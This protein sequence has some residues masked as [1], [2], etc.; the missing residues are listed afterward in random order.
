MR[1]N[2]LKPDP[3]YQEKAKDRELINFC[4]NSAR[5][6]LELKFVGGL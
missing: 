2:E 1:E 5:R 4:F 3:V 6:V